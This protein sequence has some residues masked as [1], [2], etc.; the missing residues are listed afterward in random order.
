MHYIIW[1]LLVNLNIIQTSVPLIYPFLTHPANIPESKEENR[2][3][4]EWKWNRKG[5]GDD[6][7][8]RGEKVI[9]VM[10]IKWEVSD[11]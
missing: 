2:E 6:E 11:M 1:Y 10:E 4:K 3:V 5:G 8:K 7:W 9:V